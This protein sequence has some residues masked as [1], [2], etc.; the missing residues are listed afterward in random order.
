MQLTVTSTKERPE[1][2]CVTGTWRWNAFLHR[3]G[4]SLAEAIELDILC[5]D[6]ETLMP[7]VLVLLEEAI[8]VG[9]I[10]LCMNDLAERPDLNPWLAGLYIDPPYRGKGYAA[11]LIKELEALARESEIIELYLYTANAERLYLK[12]GWTTVE[13]FESEGQSYSIMQKRLQE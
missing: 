1:L 3:S 13:T 4:K 7:T 8:P 11:R 9:M 2:A 12:Q 5:A 10:A 6:G